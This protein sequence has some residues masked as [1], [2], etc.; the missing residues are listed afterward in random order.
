MDFSPHCGYALPRLSQHRSCWQED[1]I[2]NKNPPKCITCPD[3][4]TNLRLTFS[5]LL[6]SGTLLSVQWISRL[7]MWPK[8]DFLP[9]ICFS[10]SSPI[11]SKWQLCPSKNSGQNPWSCPGLLFFYHIPQQSFRKT[12]WFC[13]QI[14]HSLPGYYCF[15]PNII[16]NRLLIGLTAPTIAPH[17]L[18][19]MHELV[20]ATPLLKI[21]RGFVCDSE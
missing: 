21:L 3:P 7:S 20:D 19:L 4:C 1:F 12:H 15:L 11:L 8:F 16:I 5:C 14:L 18:L 17:C 2:I 13:L 10:L 6:L 9:L